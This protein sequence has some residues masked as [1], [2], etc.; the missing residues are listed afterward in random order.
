[1]SKSKIASL[2]FALLILLG[3]N[4]AVS[5]QSIEP[6]PENNLIQNPWFRDGNRPSLEGWTDQAGTNAIWSLSQ[7]QSNP[8]PDGVVGT[9]ARLA[10][11]SGQG[12]GV[13]QA[14]VDAYLY[15]V[16]EADPSL[17]HLLFK[18]HWVT[19]WIDRAAVTVYG[20]NSADGPWTVVWTPL[21]VDQFSSTGGAWTQTDLLDTTIAEGFPFYKVELFGR[22][23]DGRQQ[24]AKYTGVYFAVDDNAGEVQEPPPTLEPTATVQ[25]AA[26]EPTLIPAE[27]TAVPATNTPIPAVEATAEPET[28]VAAVSTSE[29]QSNPTERPARPN[30]PTRI[31]PQPDTVSNQSISP[32]YLGILAVL[33]LLVLVLG[34]GWFRATRR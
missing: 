24:G 16:V 29:P 10:F 31:A 1:M 8:S 13:G 17:T 34:I 33:L 6:L 15:Q 32:I 12:G 2:I 19:Q 7:K 9:S 4:T 11:G 30:Q 5:A 18:I 14:G 3:V 27:E 26:P 21:E 25:T 20:G 23:P 28:E 22:Y